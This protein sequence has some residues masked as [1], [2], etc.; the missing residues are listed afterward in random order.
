MTNHPA[1]RFIDLLVF[2][3]LLFM[4]AAVYFT[5]HIE[6]P[7]QPSPTTV[8]SSTSHSVTTACGSGR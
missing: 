8:I 4:L 1:D 7:C 5:N 6:V 3:L 2:A